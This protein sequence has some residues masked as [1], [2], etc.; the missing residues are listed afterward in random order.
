[1]GGGVV[2]HEADGRQY[3]A[4]ASGSPSGFWVHKN[5]G[6]P[7]IVVFGLPKCGERN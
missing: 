7:T 5:G 2:T 4:A 3:V 6:A 1:M